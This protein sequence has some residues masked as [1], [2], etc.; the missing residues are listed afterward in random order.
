MELGRLFEELQLAA[1]RVDI[2]VRIERLRP[3][4]TEGGEPRGGLCVLRGSR[5]ILVDD[6]GTLTERI[7]TLASSLA[8]VDLEHIYLPPVVRATIGAHRQGLAEASAPSPSVEPR[9]LAKAR[10]RP[11]DD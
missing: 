11:G 6:R 2:A 3:G 10:H 4:P 1:N 9:P 8:K 7:A 5:V